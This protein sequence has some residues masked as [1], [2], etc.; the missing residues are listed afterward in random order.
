MP[1]LSAALTDFMTTDWPSRSA[2]YTSGAVLCRVCSDVPSLPACAD[3]NGSLR[4][5][6]HTHAAHHSLQAHAAVPAA[7]ERL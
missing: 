2:R 5:S 6:L 1:T 3:E 7:R 4:Y